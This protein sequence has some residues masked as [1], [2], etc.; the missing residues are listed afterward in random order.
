MTSEPPKHTILSIRSPRSSHSL[1][2][3]I[4]VQLLRIQWLHISQLIHFRLWTNSTHAG[5]WIGS[6]WEER[7]KNPCEMIFAWPIRSFGALVSFYTY[8]SPFNLKLCLSFSSCS[9]VPANWFVPCL[10]TAFRLLSLGSPGRS[11][12]KLR[13]GKLS[14]TRTNHGTQYY[15]FCLIV[16]CQSLQQKSWDWT[17]GHL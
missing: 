2:F 1:N 16:V 15:W 14:Y 8:W 6:P 17:W 13:S 11:I 12:T 5:H 3:W 9:L 4:C 7:Y 10:L